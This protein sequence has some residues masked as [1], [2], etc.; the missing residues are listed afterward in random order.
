MTLEQ[1]CLGLEPRENSFCYWLEYKTRRL[2]SVAGGNAGKFVVYYNQETKQ[3]VYNNNRYQTKEQAFEAIKS[4]LL[5]FLRLGDEGKFSQCDEIPPFENAPVVRGK[6]LNMYFPEKFLPIFSL[7]HLKD[8]C[9]QLG[10]QANLESPTSMNLA[11][12]RF[13]QTNPLVSDWSNDKFFTFL[14]EKY[15]PT[16]QFWKIAPGENARLWSQCRDGGFIC[17]GWG[18]IGDMRQY[19]DSSAFKEMYKELDGAQKVR[20]SKEIWSF[21][22]EI[23]KGDVIVSNNGLKSIV[24]VGRVTGDYWYDESRAEY[25]HCIPVIWDITSEFP[26]PESARDIA[27]TWFQGTVKK[28]DRQEYNLLLAEGTDGGTMIDEGATESPRISSNGRYADICKKTFLPEAFFADCERLLATKKQ[29]V[30]QGAPGTGKTFVAEQLATLW[31]GDAERVKVVQF[32]ES[33]GYE[34]FVHG[35][36]PERD[37][38]SKQTAFVPTPG[39]FLRFCEEIEKDKTTPQ[40]HYVLLIDEIN[41]AKTARV[42]GELLYLLEY[43]EKEVELQNGTRFS[44]PPNLYIIGTMNTTDKSIALVDYALRRRFAFVDLFPV[45]NGQSVVLRKWL[46][47]NEIS[48]AAEVDG[49]FIAL[50]A[51]IAQKD[52]AL[53]VGHSYF[54]LKQAV[55]EKRFSPELLRFVWDYYILPLIA[56]YEYQSTRAELEEKYGLAAFREALK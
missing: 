47:S 19:T 21:A 13:K 35:L 38:V 1:Y 45:I 49:L 15:P 14:Y 48:N 22:K 25:K 55:E 50:N 42:F 9:V 44:I 16:I 29:I 46:E 7:D 51:A 26:V 30:L 12:L 4:G 5:V 31:A 20:Y 2:G 8:L 41:R 28:L 33:Y 56:E 32:H 17:V 53:M 24:G 11:L 18:K 3:F 39:I 54:M 6:I 40:P 27:K 36:K 52:E 37:P 10:I 43:R 23:K 34:D